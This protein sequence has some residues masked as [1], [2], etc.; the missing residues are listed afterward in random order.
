MS[1]TGNPPPSTGTTCS[2]CGLVAATVGSGAA[3]AA[4]TGVE[5]GGPRVWA[6]A[7]LIP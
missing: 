7:K 4:V 6:W 2:G 3:M 5:V 1:Q